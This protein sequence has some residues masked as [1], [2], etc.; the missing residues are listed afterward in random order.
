MKVY[1]LKLDS[2]NTA[3]KRLRSELSASRR[4]SEDRQRQNEDLT[5][6]VEN[7][8]EQVAAGSAIKGRGVSLIAYNSHDKVTDRSSRT[9]YLVTNLSLL[10]ND[11]AEHGPVTVYVRVKDPEGIVLTNTS[12]REFSSG[13]AVM[14]ASASRTVDYEGAE[15]DM[16]IYVKDT[17]EF[18]KG[19]Y[20]VEVY[21]SK[22][23][24]GKAELLLR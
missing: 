14:M 17:G 12:S 9:V 6:A 3:N 23:M 1:I 7:L 18:I 21:T 16:S 20:S 8:S 22:S 13:G 11:L 10:E 2:L 24:I 15:V 5:R 4:E 19:M